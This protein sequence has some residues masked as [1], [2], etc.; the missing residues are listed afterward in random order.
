M[1]NQ[2]LLEALSGTGNG[3]G[4]VFEYVVTPTAYGRANGG[5]NTVSWKFEDGR[6]I[7]NFNVPDFLFEKVADAVKYQ[8]KLKIITGNEDDW[9]ATIWAI[10]LT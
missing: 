4:Q 8:K 9:G 1:N 2:S 10:V 3:G 5:G 7:S 6:E